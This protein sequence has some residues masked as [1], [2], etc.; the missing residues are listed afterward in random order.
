MTVTAAAE[1]PPRACFT[2]NAGEYVLAM[3]AAVRAV[4]RETKG[5]TDG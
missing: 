1:P 3:R 2:L 5:D 4:P